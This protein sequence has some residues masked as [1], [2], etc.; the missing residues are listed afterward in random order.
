MP[1]ISNKNL[2]KEILE[3][4]LNR[5]AKIIDA[6]VRNHTTETLIFELFTETERIML[7]KR[8]AV[9]M[10]RNKGLSYYSIS[11][12]LQISPSTAAR[13]SLGVEIGKYDK[14]IRIINKEDRSIT[15]LLEKI[16]LAGMPPRGRGRWKYVFRNL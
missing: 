8:L 4:L 7:A 16:L 11:E 13:I 2:K 3:K 9:I 14:L 6:S 5:F 10:M 15:Y 12:S 1:H